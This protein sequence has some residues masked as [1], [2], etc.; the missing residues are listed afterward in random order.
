VRKHLHRVCSSWLVINFLFTISIF[1]QDFNELEK[2]AA[3][4]LK[5]RN[6]AGVA[7]AIVKGDKMPL[8]KIGED[9]FTFQFP[10]NK[11]TEEIVIKPAKD[12]KTMILNQFVWG[13]R[14][15]SR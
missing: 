7:V 11:R 5:E 13:F 3:A 9:R 10:G 4:E 2:V 1:A 6:A 8:Q 15:V 12:G 14:R